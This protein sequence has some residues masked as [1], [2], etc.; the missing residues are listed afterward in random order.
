[1]YVTLTNDNKP[2]IT[3][4][5]FNIQ[6]IIII[7]L[8]LFFFENNNNYN[9][10]PIILFIILYLLWC[11][12]LEEF[13]NITEKNDESIHTILTSNCNPNNC[14]INVWSKDKVNIPDDYEATNF[15]TSAGCCIIPSKFKKELIGRFGNASL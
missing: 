7:V 13:K 4:G 2:N 1:M 15:S 12:N 3:S 5:W 9:L 10:Y 6:H 8:L 11:H 14:N